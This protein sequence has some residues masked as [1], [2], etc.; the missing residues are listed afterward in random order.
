MRLLQ[1]C[2][3]D[4]T[5]PGGVQR[6]V[7]DLSAALAEAGHPVTIIAPKAGATAGDGVSLRTLGR[8]RSWGLH[9][10]RFELTWASPAELREALAH[11]RTM[12]FDVAHFHTPWTPLMPWQLLRGLADTV[13]R[14]VAT[15]HDTPPPTLSGRVLRAAFSTMS[16]RLSARLQAMVGVS[17][18]SAAHLRPGVGCPLILLPPCIDLRP[19][20][21]LPAPD[22]ERSAPTVLFVGR[23]EPRKGVLLLIEAFDRVRQRHPEARLVICGDG[24]QRAP[25]E[26]LSLQ[27]RL[28]EAMRFTGQLDEAAKLR[29]YGEAMVFCAPSPYGES[30]GL[31]IAE[32]IAA[33]LPVVAAANPGYRTVLQ[34][35]G[36]EGLVAPND[37]VALAEGLQRVLSSPAMRR[38]LSAWG[39]AHATRSDVRARLPEF[40]SLYSS[41]GLGRP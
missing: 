31:V 18:S 36:A 21:A 2:P 13:P 28:G 32:A 15:F 30:Y 24:E 16:R 3:Y 12:G 27:L 17:E 35:A 4:L 8:S 34:G 40:L 10:T 25:A 20:L 14:M 23:L 9:G 26:A 38:R 29:L 39:R 7:L 22:L 5:R 19:C 6:H 1:V 37:P 41:K 11:I 33:G